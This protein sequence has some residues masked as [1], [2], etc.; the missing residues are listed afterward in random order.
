MTY[1][2][3]NGFRLVTPYLDD[4]CFGVRKTWNGLQLIEVTISSIKIYLNRFST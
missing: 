4:V 1:Q 3:F 2:Y